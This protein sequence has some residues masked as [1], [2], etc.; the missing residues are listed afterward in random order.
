[1]HA[2]LILYLPMWVGIEE[3][4]EETMLYI[5]YEKRVVY[6]RKQ[7]ERTL[8]GPSSNLS[9]GKS[10]AEFWTGLTIILEKGV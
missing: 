8:I 5:Y 10:K 3:K 2:Y 9:I 1:M 4:R 6:Q 7:R